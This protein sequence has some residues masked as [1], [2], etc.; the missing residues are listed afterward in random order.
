MNRLL[1]T[2]QRTPPT[3]LLFLLIAL[4]WAAA[5]SAATLPVT[6]PATSAGSG[7]RPLINATF[8]QL[9]EQNSHWERSR[10]QGMFDTLQAVGVR[11]VFIQW[12]LHDDRAFYASG[13]FAMV[14]R[15]PLETILAMAQARGMEVHLGLAAE[16]R[17]WE[18]IK[19]APERRGEYLDRLRWKS[20]RVARELA[21]LASRFQAFRGWYIPEEIDDFSWRAPRDQQ[22]LRR[23]LKELS[24][25]LKK[26]TP[27]ATVSLS[28]FT[29]ARSDPEFY[30][31]FWSR[32]LRETALDLVLF[33]DGAG[34]GKLP[35][36]LLPVYLKAVRSAVDA[37]AKKLQVVVELFEEV[38]EHPFKAVPAPISRVREQLRTAG[39]YASGGIN[40]FSVPD[41]MSGEA[42]AAGEE[43]LRGYLK[44]KEG[45]Q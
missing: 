39:D 41:Y 35:R 23:H 6:A 19:Q 32:L 26:L 30:A 28:G 15:P 14:P 20:E 12:T 27:A 22:L 7:K 4:F 29:G 37:N 36:E 40:S 21:P 44:Y 16:S 24:A 34:T 42:G 5:A 18:M 45:G 8:I 17:Y 31:A 33:Q 43:L 9:L 25:F 13:E 11:Q 10:W 2:P 3:A 38:S 1:K